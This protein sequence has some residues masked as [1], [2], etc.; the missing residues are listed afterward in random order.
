MSLVVSYVGDVFNVC[1]YG[2]IFARLDVWLVF[3][4]NLWKKEADLSGVGHGKSNE[5]REI[6]RRRRAFFIFLSRR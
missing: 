4:E 6:V 3:V 1:I 2:W 5:G